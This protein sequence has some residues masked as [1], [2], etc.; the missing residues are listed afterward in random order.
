MS[1]ALNLTNTSLLEI[2]SRAP[3]ELLTFPHLGTPQRFAASGEHGD[4]S[5]V[6]SSDSAANKAPLMDEPF[7][8]ESHVLGHGHATS[9]ASIMDI[10]VAPSIVLPKIEYPPSPKLSKLD[11]SSAITVGPLS[12]SQNMRRFRMCA[13]FVTLF[14]A[15]WKYVVSVICRNFNTFLTPAPLLLTSTSY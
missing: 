9:N 5:G 4:R 1:A 10:V 11:T 7:V 6:S 2:E 15:G 3:D 14:L 8:K 13:S 12:E